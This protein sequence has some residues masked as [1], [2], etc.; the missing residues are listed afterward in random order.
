MNPGIDIIGGTLERRIALNRA[1]RFVP[2]TDRGWD[3]PP[4]FEAPPIRI[5]RV[6]GR[7]VTRQI[8]WRLV[9]RR[10]PQASQDRRSPRARETG[11]RRQRGS[12]TKRGSPSSRS[13]EDE[14]P[15]QRLCRCGRPL[16]PGSARQRR[17]CDKCRREQNAR[18]QRD[19][20][21]RK[22]ASAE[23]QVPPR[24]L[25]PS[26][27]NDSLLPKEGLA[28]EILRKQDRINELATLRQQRWTELERENGDREI[29]ADVARLTEVLREGYEELRWLR[30]EARRTQSEPLD[31]ILDRVKPAD[32]AAL[33]L[34][35]RSRVAWVSPSGEMR[36]ET[37][38]PDERGRCFPSSRATWVAWLRRREA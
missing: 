31:E 33:P 10:T 16:P 15:P 6:E 1:A 26:P 24:R 21:A 17:L 34:P 9:E 20:K 23:R 14:P 11:T 27:A 36:G 30:L 38:D 25:P 37:T 22:R 7:I 19:F 4:D 13:S 5:E 28:L 18:H 8:P 2:G 12:A 29:S 3:G 35:A 32:R